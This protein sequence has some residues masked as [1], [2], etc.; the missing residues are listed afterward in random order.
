MSVIND[1]ERLITLAIHTYEYATALKSLLESEGIE[2]ELNNVNLSHPVISAGI[3]VRIKEHDLP[4]A[5]RIVENHEIF[6]PLVSD[7]E[8]EETIV[9]PTDFSQHSFNA[10]KVAFR[11][12]SIHKT[13]IVLLHSYIDPARSSQIQL[14][15]VYSYD[16]AEEEASEQIARDAKEEMSKF[17]HKIKQGIKSGEIPA[18]KFTSVVTEG[19]PEEVIIEYA[20]QNKPFLLVMGT[21]EAEK[22]ERDLIGSVTAEVL[23]SCRTTI[24]TIPSNSFSPNISQCDQ[25]TFLC[26]LD[27]GD[28]LALD[29]LTRILHDSTATVS[30]VHLPSK[31]DGKMN[32]SHAMD[33]LVD[34]CSKNYRNLK[35]EAVKN[36][37]PSKLANSLNSSDTRLLVM[38]NKK[39]NIFA[40]LFNPTI[41]HRLLFKADIPM[42]VIPI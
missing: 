29:T 42:M 3:R 22:K 20:K 15:D 4:Q 40:R 13:G 12:A 28:I 27:Q 16:I 8:H 31:K 6:P 32:V 33:V 41:A 24:I 23:D 37:D 35:F 18:A 9:V 30:L 21:R 19:V 26:N 7:D 5:L 34:Y 38:A 39:K 25:I 10:A 14:S 1:N 36:I 2:V 17:I 11:I